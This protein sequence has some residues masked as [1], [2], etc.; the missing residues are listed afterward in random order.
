M[1]FAIHLENFNLLFK[2]QADLF[3]HGIT[4]V[5][6]CI[7]CSLDT[8]VPPFVFVFGCSSWVHDESRVF[9]LT[10]SLKETMANKD[11]PTIFSSWDS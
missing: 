5:E 2:T 11:I 6:I 8:R 10:Y 7:N 3:I 4:Y 1:P 9:A